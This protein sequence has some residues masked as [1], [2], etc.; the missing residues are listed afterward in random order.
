MGFETVSMSDI[1]IEKPAPLPIGDYVFQLLPGSEFR[2]NKYNGLEELNCSAAVA[3][4]DFAGRRVFWNYP[5]PTAVS[6][7]GKPLTWS[8]QAM[9]KLEIALGTDSLPNENPKDY[10]NRVATAAHNRFSAKLAAGNYTAPGETE[11]RVEFQIF[12]VGP[13]A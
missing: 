11:P 10:F 8:A 9:K 3:D 7:T 1:K 13:A 12:S 4:G 6:K 2:T 5:D